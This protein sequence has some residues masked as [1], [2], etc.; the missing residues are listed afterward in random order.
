M[1]VNCGNLWQELQH[2]DERDEWREE[3]GNGSADAD[4]N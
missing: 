4:R 2:R 3:R 1:C